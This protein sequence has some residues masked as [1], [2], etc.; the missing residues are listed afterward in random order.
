MLQTTIRFAT[1]S[2]QL[3][4]LKAFTDINTRLWFFF[5]GKPLEIL[6]R[7]PEQTVSHPE[8]LSNKNPIES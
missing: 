8:M 5:Q 7:I 3:S 6:R 4:R 2:S 1:I